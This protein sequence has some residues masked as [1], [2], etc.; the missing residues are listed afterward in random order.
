MAQPN[1][2]LSRFAEL[3]LLPLE[4]FGAAGLRK[5]DSVRHLLLLRDWMAD[6]TG[7]GGRR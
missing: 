3:D 6:D 4:H 1:L 7:R 2:P 5:S